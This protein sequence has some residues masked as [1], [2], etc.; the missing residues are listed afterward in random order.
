MAAVEAEKDKAKVGSKG[1]VKSTAK[2]GKAAK[3]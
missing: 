2:A 3:R 1:P